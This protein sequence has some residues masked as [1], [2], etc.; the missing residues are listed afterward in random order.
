MGGFALTTDGLYLGGPFAFTNRGPIAAYNLSQYSPG[1]TPFNLIAADSVT[2]FGLY[3]VTT[4]LPAGAGVQ[5]LSLYSSGA[6]PP[7]YAVATTTTAGNV[8]N[9]VLV[10]SGCTMTLGADLAMSLPQGATDVDLRGILNADN[11]AIAAA[12]VYLGY[13]GGPF[14][15]SN[16][17]TISATS[18]YVSSQ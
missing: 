6:T 4:T 14:T 18:L 15:L 11:H 9:S 8:V 13:Y 7:V 2:N 17:G 1:Q 16:R 3:G 5:N 12:T 10:S